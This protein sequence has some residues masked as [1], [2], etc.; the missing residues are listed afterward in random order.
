MFAGGASVALAS[1]RGTAAGST[2]LAIVAGAPAGAFVLAAAPDSLAADGISVRAITASGLADA[3]ANPVT[4]GEPF[5]VSTTLGS[6]ATADADPGTPGVQVAAAA[7]T[8]SF[9]LLGGTALGTATVSAASVRGSSSGSA[10]VRLVPGAVSADSSRVDA[11]TPV[12]VGAPGSAV[13]VTLR[14]RAGPALPGVPAESIAVNVRDPPR[15]Q[16]VAGAEH[17]ES[18]TGKTGDAAAETNPEIP[19]QVFAEGPRQVVLQR[20]E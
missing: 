1:E 16:A 13:T 9:D 3:F 14:D 5:T 6:I 19:G 17:S 8:I 4:D 15:G 20:G 2:A 11:S 10:G 12:A 7:G 18:A